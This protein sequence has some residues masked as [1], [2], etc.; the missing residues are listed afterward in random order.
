MAMRWISFVLSLLLLWACSPQGRIDRALSAAEEVVERRADSALYH[1]YDIADDVEQVGEGSRALYGLLLTEAKYRQNEDKPDSLL[2]VIRSSEEWFRSAGDQLH[3]ERSM[4]YHA[5]MLKSLGKREPSALKL[6]EG[7]L[8]AEQL[9]DDMFLSKYYESLVELNY[10]SQSY[11]LMLRHAKKF[12]RHSLTHGYVDCMTRALGE[13]AVSYSQLNEPDSSLFY[14]Q[15]SL[16]MLDS[17]APLERACTFTNMGFKLI[18]H[19]DFAD[20]VT[21][22]ENALLLA[23]ITGA[24]VGLGNISYVKGDKITADSLWNLALLFASSPYRIELMKTILPIL[25]E[26]G[27]NERALKMYNEITELDDSIKTVSQR[28]IIAELQ[29]KYDQQVVVNK[30]H[31]IINY[32]FVLVFSIIFLGWQLHRYIVYKFRNVIESD[33]RK[34]TSYEQRLEILSDDIRN[35]KDEYLKNEEIILKYQH[36]LEL[37]TSNQAEIDEKQKLISSLKERNRELTR[38]KVQCEYEFHKIMQRKQHLYEENCY[39]M[40]IGSIVY[41]R[42]VSEQKLPIDI[43]EYEINLIAFYSIRRYDTYK[44]WM[45]KYD[46]LTSSMLLYLILQD[47]KYDDKA[48]ASILSVSA[49]AIKKTKKRIKMCLRRES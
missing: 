40:G 3:Q 49:D 14:F 12:L 13:I 15:Q 41:D 29:M 42:I 36:Q 6:K 26:G 17:I 47:M 10:L 18:D 31:T 37:L 43:K 8:L 32:I 7:E 5:M 22:F 20:A 46:G 27:E 33:A 35:K 38:Q 45:Q 39:R 25:I 1:L 30:A 19:K 24:Y 48:I 9:G 11:T 2:P 21:C 28:D 4:Y 44:G 34:I 16:P 23:P